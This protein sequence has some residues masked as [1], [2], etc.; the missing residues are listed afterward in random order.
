MQ[1]TERVTLMTPRVLIPFVIVTLIWGSTYYVVKDQLGTVPGI[2]SV[3]FRFIIASAAMFAVALWQR[4]PL[5]L[6]RKGHVLALGIGVM[7]FVANYNFAYAS[8]HYLTSGL[9]AVLFA[10]LIVPNS[11][12]G[13]IWLRQPLRRMF[14]AGAAIAI[15]GVGMMIAHEVEVAPVGMGQVLTG[16]AL[17]LC[18]MLAASVANVVQGSNL[19]RKQHMVVMLAWAMLWGAVGDAVLAFALYGVPP[20]ELRL[21]YWAGLLWLAIAGSVV[22]FPL[23]FN[24]IRAV[25]PGQ[26]A[27]SSV[28]IPII[29]MTLS[30]LFEGYVWAPLSIGGALLVMVGL[31]VALR[32]EDAGVG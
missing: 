23:Y 26:A 22:T 6:T 8:Q 2:W 24:V 5:N 10:L 31:V 12:A 11:V 16:T 19:A 14:I 1:L 9:L 21:S 20:L 15:I 17:G 13:A 30:T 18:A 28:L 27:W 4:L 7:Q 32:P 25:G 3:T 29:A